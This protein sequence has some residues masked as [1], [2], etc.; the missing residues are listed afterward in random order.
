MPRM[1]SHLRSAV[2]INMDFDIL[3]KL[4]KY[5]NG[6]GIDANRSDVVNDLIRDGYRWRNRRQQSLNDFNLE[7]IKEQ[8]RIL[9]LKADALDKRHQMISEGIDMKAFMKEGVDEE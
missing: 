3:Q 6:T 5:K 1:T 9:R 7:E 4:E 2:S 8:A